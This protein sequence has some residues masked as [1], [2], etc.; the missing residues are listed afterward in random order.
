MVGA[1]KK[2][3]IL[4]GG[5]LF[6]KTLHAIF[7]VQNP[8]GYPCPYTI[9]WLTDTHAIAYNVS[10]QG[11]DDVPWLSQRSSTLHLTGQLE[12]VIVFLL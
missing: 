8:Q 2:R 3:I 6:I 7:I 12:S 10:E 5:I 9:S 1:S 11:G 4:Y